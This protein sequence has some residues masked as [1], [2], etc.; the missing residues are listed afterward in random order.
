M[1]LW[2]PNTFYKKEGYPLWYH[3]KLYSQGLKLFIFSLQN[4]KFF[5]HKCASP[6]Q[7]L[8]GGQLPG[9]RWMP[10]AGTRSA[11]SLTVAQSSHLVENLPKLC[12]TITFRRKALTKIKLT[13]AIEITRDLF[14]CIVIFYYLS[15]SST[16]KMIVVFSLVKG[17]NPILL[18]NDV[19]TEDNRDALSNDVSNHNGV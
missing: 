1:H 18:F 8:S 15:A 11:L 13:L 3:H 19:N 10:R 7:L 12:I 17:L 16:H 6:L 14:V 4:K 2:L 9:P 5:L